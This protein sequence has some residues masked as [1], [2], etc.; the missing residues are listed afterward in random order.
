MCKIYICALS[1]NTKKEA[2]VAVDSV[3]LVAL[4]LVIGVLA[5]SMFAIL[6]PNFIP[7]HQQE[8]KIDI[9]MTA[10]VIDSV[11]RDIQMTAVVTEGPVG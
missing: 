11:Q 6:G 1:V 3:N 5:I 7:A 8:K 10:Y 4:A 2:K 9:T